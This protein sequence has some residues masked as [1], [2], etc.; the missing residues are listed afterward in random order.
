[1]ASEQE[2]TSLNRWALAIFPLPRMAGVSSAQPRGSEAHT[3]ARRERCPQVRRQR[4]AGDA[5]PH[6]DLCSVS[7]FTERRVTLG[8][9]LP[10]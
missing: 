4:K 7:W 3:Q 6:P 9:S 5:S 10:P 8:Q 2:V 1:M